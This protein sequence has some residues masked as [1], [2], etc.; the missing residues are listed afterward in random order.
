VVVVTLVKVL[1][2]LI[3]RKIFKLSA[4]AGFGSDCG[5]WIERISSIGK[6]GTSWGFAQAKEERGGLVVV[7]NGVALA[8]LGG[9]RR[10]VTVEGHGGGLRLFCF[11]SIVSF[12]LW[13]K[14]ERFN[15][16]FSTE[17]VKSK[18]SSP[19]LVGTKII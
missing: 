16:Q 11:S 2:G 6:V 3:L 12:S 18:I 13:R 4:I 9:F 14:K 15:F 17:N 7:V 10:T 19:I 8:L 5:I 1:N